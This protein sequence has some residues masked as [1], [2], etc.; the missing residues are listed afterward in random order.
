MAYTGIKNV[1]TLRK[2]VNGVATNETKLNSPSDPDYIAPYEDLISCPIGYEPPVEPDPEPEQNFSNQ[3]MSANC[4]SSTGGTYI[5][6]N[7]IYTINATRDF[8]VPVETTVNMVLTA[9][10]TA[11][12]GAVEAYARVQKTGFGVAL[13]I[14]SASSGAPVDTDSSNNV[15]LSPGVYTMFIYGADCDV[16]TF[17]SFSLTVT[18]V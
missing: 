5:E 8:D 9:N 1:L 16:S 2:Y 6:N 13:G 12:P 15:T 4:S 3:Y 10:F 14:V 18:E 17:G 11:G 7:V